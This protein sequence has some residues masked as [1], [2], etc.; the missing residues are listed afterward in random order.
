MAALAAVRRLVAAHAARHLVLYSL[1]LVVASHALFHTVSCMLVPVCHASHVH[2]CA[3]W[4]RLA[5]TS[6]RARTSTEAPRGCWRR[7][8][9]GMQAAC[10]REPAT[11]KAGNHE[12]T[13]EGWASGSGEWR[14]V[15]PVLLVPACVCGAG[16]AAPGLH[17]GPI[18]RLRA[19]A[20][21][22]SNGHTR[23]PAQPQHLAGMCM[24]ICRWC[25][26]RACRCPMWT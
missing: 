15:S 3:S 7:R 2:R 21:R 20:T 14:V 25:P 11:R 19:Y 12:L 1:H 22:R 8:V 5:S 23:P 26:R 17:S 18:T 16:T 9:A 6:W 24:C 10:V 13:H 4:C